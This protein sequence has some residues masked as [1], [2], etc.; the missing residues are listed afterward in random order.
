MSALPC[1]AVLGRRAHQEEREEL[2]GSV[3]PT[4]KAG[5]AIKDVRRE[6]GCGGLVLE[7]AE[8]GCGLLEGGLEAA[9]EEVDDGGGEGGG[10]G[11]GLGAGAVGAG[12]DDEGV[13]LEEA[14]A[15]A[16]GPLAEGKAHLDV[17]ELQRRGGD[18][19]EAV[20][21]GDGTGDGE[22]LGHADE[23]VDRPALVGS[24]GAKRALGSAL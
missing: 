5:E 13:V 8:L 16:D 9:A 15:L 17:R 19:E 3:V 2:E 10:D 20:D 6:M 18:V 12:G 11:P 4:G 7:G 1:P 14:E 22:D 21:L 24:E 23:I